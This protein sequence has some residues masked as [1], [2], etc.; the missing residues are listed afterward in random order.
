M[1]L[2]PSR[3]DALV[4]SGKALSGLMAAVSALTGCGEA[5]TAANDSNL[6]GINAEEPGP[7]SL[8]WNSFVTE[9]A[10]RA[11]AQFSS[12]WNQESYVQS[13]AELMYSLDLNDP[14]VESFFTNYVNAAANFPEI[15][16][17]HWQESFQVSVLEFEQGEVIGLQVVQPS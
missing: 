13:I 6:L 4:L 3:R 17:V 7:I 2:P 8:D 14:Q 9:V 15:T 11:E 10:S 1:T 12:T 16:E 5:G